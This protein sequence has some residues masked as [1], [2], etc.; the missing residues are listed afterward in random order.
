[1][2]PIGDLFRYWRSRNFSPFTWGWVLGLV[3]VGLLFAFGL[4]AIPL[5][6]LMVALFV[7][8]TTGKRKGGG[9]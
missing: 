5:L 3:A 2:R 7:Y 6:A 9:R 4:W 1:M 8:L